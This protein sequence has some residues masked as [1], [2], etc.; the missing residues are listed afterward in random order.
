MNKVKVGQSN[1]L[2][3]IKDT[4]VGYFF[5]G[6]EDGDILMPTRHQP[7]HE[8]YIGEELEVFV[9]HDS[10]ERLTATVNFPVAQ[11]GE[12]AFLKVIDNNKFGVFLDWGLTRDLFV[13]DYEQY[14]PMEIGKSYI[15]RISLDNYGRIIGSSFINSVIK[16]NNN[17]TFKIKQK[18]NVLIVENTE[19]GWRAIINNTHWGIIYHNEI[20]KKISIGQSIEAYIK[21][22][23]EDDKIDLSLVPQ[24]FD[25]SH[26]GDL[27]KKI[28]DQI[29][30]HNGFLPITD[31]SEPD[32]IL[33]LFEVSK[34]KFKQA[35]GGLYR[36]RLIIIEKD[37]L[38]HS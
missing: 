5:D 31:K 10:Q 21:N 4:S 22:I 2:T 6:G 33:E 16:E 30:K 18:V 7:D 3:V 11:V 32:E 13:P 12:L 27:G 24:G 29:D 23:R 37:G 25:S 8:L 1:L 20:F 28:L 36:D 14:V 35:V 26:I 17:K 34:K 9:F 15:V 38:R 19:I